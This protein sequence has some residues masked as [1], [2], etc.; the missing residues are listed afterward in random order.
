[1][2]SMTFFHG[3]SGWSELKKTSAREQGVQSAHASA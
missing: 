1:V 3:T 2:R